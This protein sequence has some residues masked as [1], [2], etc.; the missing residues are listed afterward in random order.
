MGKICRCAKF[1]WRSQKLLVAAVA[2]VEI[3]EQ[4]TFFS[5]LDEP[6]CRVAT[7]ETEK[8]AYFT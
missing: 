1:I 7:A 8:T 3:S 4:K 6:T 2:E 5:P